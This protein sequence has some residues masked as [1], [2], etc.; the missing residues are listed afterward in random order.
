MS[1][2]PRRIAITGGSGFVGQ[3]LRRRIEET[4]C[5][6]ALPIL[7]RDDQD[8]RDTQAVSEAVRSARPDV[9]IHLAA[10]AAPLQAREA[11][12]EAWNVNVLGTL[13]LATAITRDAPDARLLFIGSSE[14]YG[15]AFTRT[16]D[17]VEEDAT[18]EPRGVYGS[19]KAVADLMLGQLARDGLKV[20]RLRP[21]NHTGPGQSSDYVVGAFAR[22][23]ALIEKGQ[24]E[25]VIRVGNLEAERDFLDVRDVVDAYLAASRESVVADGSAINIG[26]GRPVKIAD[27]LSVLLA[28]ARVPIRIEVDSGRFRA[29]DIPRASGSIARA[30]TMLNWRP[31]IDLATTLQDTLDDWRQRAG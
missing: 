30:G 4:G 8:I 13:N 24:Q 3:W 29:N 14:A 5:D 9:L 12:A 27:I 15:A 6:V 31:R 17:P 1:T 18:L 26:T 28:L 19:T 23:I 10:I 16:E 20:L 7:S 2:A 21:F 11:P 25:P 22:Q